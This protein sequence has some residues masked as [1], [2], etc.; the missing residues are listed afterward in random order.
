MILS[1]ILFLVFLLLGGLHLC[2][3][4]GAEYGFLASLPTKED[5]KVLFVPRKRDSAIVGAGLL[6]MAFF[7][8]LKIGVLPYQLPENMD[9][10]VSWLI[11][12]IF[13]LRSIGEFKYVGFF[14]KVKNTQFA[15]RDT[16]YYSPLCFLM[17][18]LGMLV[19]WMS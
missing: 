16:S 1:A 18:F 9:F 15:S 10:H 13:L 11:P 5:G 2:W 19:M 14:K 3:A 4:F 7:Y 17:G 12:S 6:S 8:L